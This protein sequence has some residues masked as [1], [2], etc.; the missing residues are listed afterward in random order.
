[1][2]QPARPA[3]RVE[4]VSHRTNAGDAPE[5][6]LA[7]IE[8]AVRDGCAAVEVDVRATRDGALVLLHDETLERTTGDR[9]R[10]D[11]VTLEEVRA[12]TVLDPFGASP[13]QRVPTLAEALEA[14]HGRI[15]IEIDL[16]MR[17]LEAAIAAEVRAADAEAWT[18]F[19]AHPPPD[20][21]FL[22][23]ACPGARVYLSVAPQ[24]TWVRDLED[25][26]EV[27]ARLGLAGINPSL[28]ALVPSTIH[29]ARERGLLVGAWTVNTPADIDRALDL[30][31]DAITTDFPA[32]VSGAVARRAADGR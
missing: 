21:A 4:V 28:G 18:W 30:G 17:G 26:I 27:A 20:A 15:A 6:T 16:P 14:L 19:T 7:G 29:E 11:S 10:I 8:A 12:L 13:P 9:R 22:R 1:M 25:A 5:N 2:P 24:P 31:V 32:R 3:P 23:D